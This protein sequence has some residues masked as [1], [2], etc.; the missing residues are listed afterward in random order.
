MTEHLCNIFSCVAEALANVSEENYEEVGL[1]PKGDKQR[2]FDLLAEEAVLNYIEANIKDTV[3]LLSEES[4]EVTIGRGLAK[5]R[6]VLDPVDGSENFARGIPLSGIALAALPADA[7][8]SVQSIEYAM[9]GDFVGN[10]CFLAEKGNGAFL[11]GNIISTSKTVDI[12]SAFISCE[13][14]H[15]QLQPPVATLLSRA[16]GVRSFGCATASLRMVAEGRLDAHIDIR[17]RLTAENFLAPYLLIREAGGVLT[18]ID[19][20]ELPEITDLQTGYSLLASSNVELH[21]NILK[22]INNEF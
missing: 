16:A 8:L 18:G 19:G 15:Y 1:N 21:E 13:L 6:L 3:T 11:R 9:V 14:G 5:Y 17:G 7:P 22:S 2:R 12:G 4:G 20:E 10:C